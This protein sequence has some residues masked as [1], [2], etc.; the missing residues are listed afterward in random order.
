MSPVGDK[1]FSNN[2]SADHLE[3][4]GE[5]PQYSGMSDNIY[6]QREI[7]PH[8][9]AMYHKQTSRDPMSW[10]HEAVKDDGSAILEKEMDSDNKEKEMKNKQEK[11]KEGKLEKPEK[12]EL[13]NNKVKSAQECWKKKQMISKAGRGYTTNN[14]TVDESDIKLRK[15]VENSRKNEENS[16]EKVYVDKKEDN[17]RVLQVLS[18]LLWSNNRSLEMK[19]LTGKSK[20]NKKKCKDKAE[21]K[22]K[23]KRSK[24]TKHSGSS[25]ARGELD[26]RDFDA[27]ER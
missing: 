14:R 19:P 21:S 6:H 1:S 9:S 25:L 12:H 18:S 22:E 27:M 11:E 13:E 23:G 17:E 8:G 15:N 7:L 3:P 20:E 26:N 5:S 4:C 24:C 16:K 10:I 2:G